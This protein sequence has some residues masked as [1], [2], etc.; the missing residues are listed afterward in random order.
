MASF[1]RSGP[2]DRVKRHV[3]PDPSE[4][5]V[6]VETS[7]I[8]PGRYAMT[9]IHLGPAATP[10]VRPRFV[11][12][13]VVLELFTAVGAIPVGLS[14]V[15]DPTGAGVG[16]PTAWIEA[17][18]FHSYLVPGLY[19]LLANGVGMLLLAALSVARHPVAPW[20]TGILGTGLVVWI[21]VQAIVLP[22]LSPL[23]LVFGLIGVA[24]AGIG[25]AWLRTTGQL[26]LG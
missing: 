13:A 25:A 22:E 24:L 2:V 18:P 9:A 7:H 8:A 10:L 23:Q 12:V 15:R 3:A 6:G 20:L 1:V 5:I 21:A 17:S 4:R 19:L 14:L 26:R 11:W 16:L